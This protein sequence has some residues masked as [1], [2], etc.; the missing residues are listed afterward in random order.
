MINSYKL[1][2]GG[3]MAYKRNVSK[4][5][6]R[7]ELNI[8]TGNNSSRNTRKNKSHIKK[9]S[10]KT[11]CVSLCLFIL[12]GALAAGAT[13][14]VSKDDCFTILG[15]EEVNLIVGDR[16]VDDG[17]K[18]V[19][20]GIDDTDKVTIETNMEQ[21]ADGYYVLEEG[22]YYIKYLVDNIKYGSIFK[23]EKIRLITFVDPTED[24]EVADE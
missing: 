2:I 22:T 24:S 17:V 3:N 4:V 8:D 5:S 11:L 13:W 14:F 6:K 19:A 16:Y 23:V 20:F 1:L 18:V 12:A 9:L 10:L 7:A 21:D 15:K